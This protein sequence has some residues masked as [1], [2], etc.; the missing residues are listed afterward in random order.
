LVVGSPIR[1]IGAEKTIYGDSDNMTEEARS[2]VLTEQGGLGISV[3]NLSLTD[4]E[5]EFLAGIAAELDDRADIDIGTIRAPLDSHPEELEDERGRWD[6]VI[7]RRRIGWVI[8]VGEGTKKH[9]LLYLWIGGDW[10]LVKGQ[11][12]FDLPMFGLREVRSHPHLPVM[13]HEGPKAWEMADNRMDGYVHVAWHGSEW[14][15]EWTDWSPL[16]GR[17]VLIWPDCDEAGIAN[18]RRLA[19]RLA[20]MGGVIEY[21]NWSVADIERF[22]GWDWA[23]DGGFSEIGEGEIR[24]RTMMVESP[25]G[26][27]GRVLAEWARRSF[28]DPERGEVYQVSR[29]YRPMPLEK[30]AKGHGKTF[31]ADVIASSINPFEGLDYRPGFPMGRMKDGRLNTCP[32]T[33]RDALAPRPFPLEKYKEISRVWLRHMIPNVRERKH[34]IRRAAWAVARPERVPQHIVVLMGDSGIGKSVLLDLIVAVSGRGVSLFPDSI[35]TTFNNLIARRSVVAVHEIHS[36]EGN[37]KWNAGKLKE[38]IANSTIEIEEK[39]RPKVTMTNVIHWFAA[40]NDKAP[41]ALEHGNDRFYFVVCG[42]PPDVGRMR[43]FF[44]KWVPIF[45]QEAFLDELCAGAKYLVDGFKKK[46]QHA[47]QGRAEPQSIWETIAAR[48]LQPWEQ[49][50]WD[51]LDDACEKPEGADHPPVFFGE[52]IVRLVEDRHKKGPHDIRRRMGEFGYQ[53]LKREPGGKAPVQLTPKG[54][55]RGVVWCRAGDLEALQARGDY[56]T[57]KP[58][59]LS[60]PD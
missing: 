31:Q 15:M 48:N 10:R 4:K 49:F 59:K 27:D 53:V 30:L 2:Y 38:L 41:F 54:G 40:T 24:A 39:N 25:V 12:C 22:G 46:T 52:D 43:R 5:R 13:I 28:L 60:G 44:R 6:L 8:R 18:A 32:P 47:M 29:K 19:K 11:P 56:G 33:P 9:Y 16:R 23:D 20:L 45:S 26:P 35:F 14:G 1:L 34:V 21:V 51:R 50:L 58:G 37:K 55:K 57:L 7:D 3:G 17:R 42:N 36:N